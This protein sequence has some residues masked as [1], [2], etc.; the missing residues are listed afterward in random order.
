M[1]K[2]A[3]FT[4]LATMV[5]AMA[6]SCSGDDG[7]GAAD[8]GSVADTKADVPADTGTDAAVPSDVANPDVAAD[9]PAPADVPVDVPKVVDP[10]CQALKTGLNT[11]FDVDG[12]KRE[13]LL[14]LPDR[15]ALAGPW[16]VVFN[17]H[18]FGDTAQNMSF[19][20]SGNVNDATYP[21]IL[22]TPDDLRALPPNGMD[23]QILKVTDKDPD[24]RLF[25][26][27]LVCL[28]QV[29]GVDPDR[30]HVMGFSAGAIMSDLLGAMRG[31]KLASIVSFSGTYFSNPPNK[32]ALGNFAALVTWGEMTAGPTYAQMLVHGGASDNYNLGTTTLKF[33][34]NGQRDVPYLNGLG[35]DVVHCDH[36]GKHTIPV[37]F[38]QGQIVRFFEAHP[39]GVAATWADSGLPA[40]ANL[41]AYC[42]AKPAP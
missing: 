5:L 3:T 34:E 17:W 25:D 8:H 30:V 21:F 10:K 19:V 26:E 13:F 18:G 36:G 15:A 6:C 24:V 4:I 22:V 38:M 1:A 31:D 20:L 16:P 2:L 23:W 14:H 37:G 32:E 35:H 28:D 7:A 9:L 27:I 42:V 11:D 12:K 40:A 41:P 39:R 29:Y 33:N